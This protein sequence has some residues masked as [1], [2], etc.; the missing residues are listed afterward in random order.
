MLDITDPIVNGVEGQSIRV[1]WH[2]H[3]VD[4]PFV[5]SAFIMM[6]PIGKLIGF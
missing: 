1:T 6:K 2:H 5:G 4:T 3:G